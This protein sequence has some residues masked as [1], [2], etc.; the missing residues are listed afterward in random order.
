MVDLL[1]GN[2]FLILF[3]ALLAM[4]LFG[5]NGYDAPSR[6][7]VFIGTLWGMLSLSAFAW[8]VYVIAHF[9]AKNW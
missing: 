4:F 8:F 1:I 6:G 5:G 7:V 3:V 9:V 2:G